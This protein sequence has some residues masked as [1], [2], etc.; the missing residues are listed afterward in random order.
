[1]SKDPEY[2]TLQGRRREDD[3]DLGHVVNGLPLLVG[4]PSLEVLG[5]FHLVIVASQLVLTCKIYK[6]FI[7]FKR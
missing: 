4:H 3:A 6:L 5:C 1:V 2:G 7:T